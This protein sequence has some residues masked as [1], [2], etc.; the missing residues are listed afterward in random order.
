[1]RLY[2]VRLVWSELG[3]AR[4]KL[5]RTPFQRFVWISPFIPAQPKSFQLKS[6]VSKAQ[7][8][9]V[10][11]NGRLLAPCNKQ[12]VPFCSPFQTGSCIDLAEKKKDGERWFLDIRGKDSGCSFGV[13][14]CVALFN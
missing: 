6:A 14:K 7:P 1:M 8:M 4:D 2:L 11:S 13:H 3:R 9:P 5:G 12:G 10:Q